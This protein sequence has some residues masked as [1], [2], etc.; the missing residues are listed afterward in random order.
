MAVCDSITMSA[1]RNSMISL[2]DVKIGAR[3]FWRLPS[4]LRHPLS[5]EE[6]RATLRQR[7]ERREVDFLTIARR[8]VYE[9]P[10]SPYRQLLKLAGCEYGDLERL[11]SKDGVESALRT[12][13]RYGVYLTVDEFKGRR[14]VVRGNTTIAADHSQLRNPHSAFHVLVRSSGSRGA[15]TPVLLD[16]AFFRDRAVDISLVLDAWGGASWLHGLWGVPGA[17]AMAQLLECSSFG[18]PPVRWFSQ[19]DPAAPG[20]HPRYRWSGRVTRWGSLLAGVPLPRAEYVPLD[21]PLPVARWMAEVLRTGRTPILHTYPSS[22][23]RVCQA[24][25]GAG[26][27]LRSARFTIVGEPFTEARQAAI[28]RTGAKALPRFAAIECGPVGLG[29]LL[30]DAPDEIH[31]FHDLCALIQ[32]GQDAKV[33]GLPGTALLISSLRSTAPFILLNVSMGDQAV[34]LRRQCGCPLERLGWTTHLHT[35][36]SHEKLTCGGIPFLDTDVIRVLEE[37]LPA[38]F[39]GAPTDYQLLEDEADDGRPRLR[40]VVHPAVGPLDNCAVADVFLTSIGNGSG[41]ERLTELVWRSSGI[42]GVERRAPR[43]TASGKVL[44]LHL[45]RRPAAGPV[46]QSSA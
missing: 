2:E 29:C 7:L 1:D 35:I 37:V 33:H 21:G 30:P 23:V 41:V 40:L 8:A 5:V 20:L 18:A 17:S 44:H 43:T 34:V 28:R 24:A 26:I 12:L 38:R 14:P 6:A 46:S 10:G 11:V 3:F 25:L 22:A 45:E 16:L 36:R 4:F 9:H 15:G 31:L 27:D 32:P 19:I 42:L 13:Y 39:G